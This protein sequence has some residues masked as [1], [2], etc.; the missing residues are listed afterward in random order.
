MI[1]SVCA[2]SICPVSYVSAYSGIDAAKYA[3]DWAKGYNTSKYYKANFDC[4]NFASQCLEA[5]GKKRT[6]K[7]ADYNSI[8]QWRPHL[9]SWEND[10]IF[11]NYWKNQGINVKSYTITGPTALAWKLYSNYSS[12]DIMQYSYSDDISKHSQIVVGQTTYAGRPT[13]RM[14]QHTNGRDDI[15]LENYLEATYYEKIKP[16]KFVV[17]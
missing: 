12:G 16:F 4:T 3:L 1:I 9:G 6:S 14:A 11:K 13:L 8:T 10:N 15:A 2:I 17:C 5:G 7:S